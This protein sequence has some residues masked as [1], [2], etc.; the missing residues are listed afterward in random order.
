[1]GLSLG[2][3]QQRGSWKHGNVHRAC[4]PACT[5][6]CTHAWRL[7]PAALLP[8]CLAADP[9]THLPSPKATTGPLPSGLLAE[10]AACQVIL[11]CHCASRRCENDRRWLV[12]V[13]KH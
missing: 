12:I 2:I 11:R 7:L 6:A 4:L 9:P 10:L 5:T 1:M 3:L 13:V 8:R